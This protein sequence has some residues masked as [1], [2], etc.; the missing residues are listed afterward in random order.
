SIPRSMGRVHLGEELLA[1]VLQHAEVLRGSIV[2]A[3]DGPVESLRWAGAMP[4]LLR[5]LAV[6]RVISLSDVL[7]RASD[8]RRLAALLR[9][10]PSAKPNDHLAVGGAHDVCEHLVV[11]TSGFLWEYEEGLQQLLGS[12]V[13]RRLTICSTIS[14]RA[15]ECCDVSVLGNRPA[16]MRFEDFATALRT[17]HRKPQC[18]PT[19]TVSPAVVIDPPVPNNAVK[20]SEDSD[21]GGDGWDWDDEAAGSNDDEQVAPEP[22]A[23]SLVQPEPGLKQ[24]QTGIEVV[25]LPLTCVPLLSTSSAAEPSL[26]VLSHPI[27]ATAFPLLLSDIRDGSG[28]PRAVQYAHVKDVQPEQ[29]PKDYRRTLK[30]LSHTLAEVLIQMRLQVKERIH[31]VGASSLKIGHTVLNN[32]HLLENELS[33]VALQDYRPATLIL[34]DRTADLASPCS[35]E[36]SLVD[37]IL[38]VL[39]QAPTTQAIHARPSFALRQNLHVTEVFGIHGCEPSPTKP[40]NVDLQPY[41]PSAFT[42]SI[43]LKSGA[44]LC[45]N[46]S[47]SSASILKSLVL[48]PAKLALRDLDKRLQEVEHELVQQ[49]K[50]TKTSSI[51]KPGDKKPPTRGRDVVLRRIC[52]VLEA[53]EPSSS[54]HIALIELGVI[55]LETLERMSIG[56]LRWDKCRERTIR[57]GQL[58]QQSGGEWILPELADTIQRQLSSRERAQDTAPSFVEFL[59]LLVHAFT[60]SGAGSIEDYT[61]QM[62]RNIAS[63][64][65][66]E[67]LPE[68]IA[69]VKLLSSPLAEE[70]ARYA[71]A[72]AASTT[73]ATQSTSKDTSDDDEWDWGE[74]ASSPTSAN[75]NNNEDLAHE[76][77]VVKCSIEAF[78]DRLM[79]PLNECS[80]H[81]AKANDELSGNS[82]DSQ[83]SHPVPLLARIADSIQDPAKGVIPEAEHVSKLAK[84]LLKRQLIIP[85]FLQIVDASEQLARVGIDL[86]KSGF[87]R[88]GFGGTGPSAARLVGSEHIAAGSDVAVVFVVGG[89]TFNEVC[90]LCVIF[91][92]IVLI[93]LELKPSSMIT[94][95]RAVHE[96]LGDN[97]RVQVIIGGTTMTN[98]EILLHQLFK[99]IR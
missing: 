96:A 57:H 88:F 87:S 1:A 46:S 24:D 85:H 49:R 41:T 36:M 38:A 33:T 75:S 22:A 64:L 32:I 76:R 99:R 59:T 2:A 11:I 73:T 35:F 92:V 15:H 82:M 4:L 53:G 34:V 93:L 37:R 98:N 28:L 25:Y 26:F 83:D 29:I 20:A 65:V 7:T 40:L 14:E 86:L 5:D 63:E 58:R 31:A 52:N 91:V 10:F 8:P 66:L 30:M 56:Q 42:A 18:S 89:V 51:R 21:E 44:N 90:W 95:V 84:A 69:H 54:E 94:Q 50:I 81:Y 47:Q 55:V 43:R 80:Q 77:L 45:H 72:L 9:S 62:I 68:S 19:S 23:R 71:D 60:L 79:Q 97:D 70:L 74:S 16:V 13:V 39:P 17:F 3:D 48:R 27:C 6:S 78:I 61:L 12:G 67:R